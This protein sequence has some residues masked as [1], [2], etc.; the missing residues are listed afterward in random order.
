MSQVAGDLDAARREYN[1]ALETYQQ[2]G[3]RLSAA[4]VELSL[5]EVSLEQGSA[6]EAEQRARSALQMLGDDGPEDMKGWGHAVL[7]RSL[8]LT[9]RPSEALA[10]ARRA[11]A[12]VAGSEHVAL[13]RHALI[14]CARILLATGSAEDALRLLRQEVVPH[15][16]EPRMRTTDLEGRLALEEAALASGDAEAEQ[17]LRELGAEARALG[18][19]LLAAKAAKAAGATESGARSPDASS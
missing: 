19:N 18:F 14:T 6:V 10:A 11:R 1:A 17:R 5:A 4:W 8:A 13:R 9:A 15:D 3:A 7:G 12:L 16:Q 2:L